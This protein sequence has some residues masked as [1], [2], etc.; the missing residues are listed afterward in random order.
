VHRFPVY[1]GEC[2]SL[3]RRRDG[4]LAGASPHIGQQVVQ[5]RIAPTLSHL[6][7]EDRGYLPVHDLG[8]TCHTHHRVPPTQVADLA[9]G[10]AAQSLVLLQGGADRAGCLVN[11][12]VELP[13]A[14]LEWVQGFLDLS[15]W[16]EALSIHD[17][18]RLVDLYLGGRLE[19][20]ALI[21]RQ[22]ELRDV[23]E[24]HRALAAGENLRGLLVF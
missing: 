23:N 9:G 15:L 13:G 4:D 14:L 6:P 7:S 17:F 21:T 19:L 10:R 16:V 22:Y 12:G 8:E 3:I 24:A 20:D 18:A 1:E 11:G 2:C 5:G